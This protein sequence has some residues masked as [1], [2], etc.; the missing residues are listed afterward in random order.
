MTNREYIAELLLDSNRSIDDW[1][2]R[3]MV[4]NAIRCPHP[5]SNGRGKCSAARGPL[6]KPNPRTQ[7]VLLAY[8][9]CLACKEEWLNREIKERK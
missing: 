6:G 8:E 7:E 9:R 1:A 4:S 3:I 2:Y 5:D